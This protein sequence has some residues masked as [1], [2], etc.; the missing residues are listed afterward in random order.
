MYYGFENN[1]PNNQQKWRHLAGL[2]LTVSIKLLPVLF[3]LYTL[4]KISEYS[5]GYSKSTSWK[6]LVG[7]RYRVYPESSI[8]HQFLKKHSQILIAP[9]PGSGT[10]LH[11][12]QVKLIHNLKPI[13]NSG[14]NNKS[15]YSTPILHYSKSYHRAAI[16][17]SLKIFIHGTNFKKIVS[18][19][20]SPIVPIAVIPKNL[21]FSI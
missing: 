11:I 5:I 4:N 2:K 10:V 17:T 16:E 21:E 8:Y 18:K 14:I 1:S 12:A 19:V 15:Y 20:N 6:N 3:V 13:D 7:I 9:R